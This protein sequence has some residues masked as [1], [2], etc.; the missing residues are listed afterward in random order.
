MIALWL[1][2][3]ELSPTDETVKIN[4]KNVLKRIRWFY[5]VKGNYLSM[6]VKRI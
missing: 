3:A 1:V 4:K 5:T 2:I 6:H